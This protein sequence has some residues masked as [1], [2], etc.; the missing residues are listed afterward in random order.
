MQM[1]PFRGR[2]NDQ[3][4]NISAFL[5]FLR[6]KWF[7]RRTQ[8]SSDMTA[9]VGHFSPSAQVSLSLSLSLSFH[10]CPRP[11]APPRQFLSHPNLPLP[12]FCWPEG[13]EGQGWGT[14]IWERGWYLACPSSEETNVVFEPLITAIIEF[15]TPF[16]VWG[17][18]W[19]GRL[20][21]L[22]NEKSNYLYGQAINK[23]NKVRG[24]C[25]HLLVAN[26]ISWKTRGSSI[27]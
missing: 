8:I 9:T 24:S 20:R 10:S 2:E 13:V 23:S 6:G 1:N 4:E 25:R 16:L 12:P 7:K 18:G 15:N 17:L 14:G 11:A 27:P 22:W 26:L 21:S 5:I 19:G 3:S